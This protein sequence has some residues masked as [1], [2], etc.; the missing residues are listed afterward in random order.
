MTF[1]EILEFLLADVRGGYDVSVGS[2]FYDLLYPVAEQIYM[3]QQRYDMFRDNAFAITASDEWLDKKAAEQGITRRAATY[4]AGMVRIKGRKGEVIIAGSK[5]AAEDI[6]FSV[7]ETAIIPDSEY[8]DVPATCTIS[9]SVGNVKAGAINRFPLTLPGLIEV[10]NPEPFTGGYDAENDADLRER[11]LDKLAH[12]AASGNVYHYIEW[13]KEVAGVGDVRVIPLWNGNGTVKVVI[14][15]SE[16]KPA[17]SEL[18]ERVAEHI[19]TQRPIGADVTVVGAEATTINISVSVVTTTDLTELKE[20]ITAAIT[21]YLSSEALDKG[22]VSYAKIGSLI[23]ASDGVEDYDDLTMNDG[24]DNIV[25]L[26]G[27]VP[28]IGEVVIT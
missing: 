16:R 21:R 28:V 15:D 24:E 8:A 13:A 19:E 23:L 10:T 3:L 20:L 7:D 25:L 6:L 18:V 27:A 26:D 1:D 9:G 4:A 11:Y 14:T 12:P 22:Y 5:V 2:F 17:D